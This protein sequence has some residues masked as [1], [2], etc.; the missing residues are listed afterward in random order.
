MVPVG[1]PARCALGQL[2]HSAT[3]A[4]VWAA[5]VGQLA[6]TGLAGA[7]GCTGPLDLQ[8]PLP[9]AGGLTGLLVAWPLGRSCP[10]DPYCPVGVPGPTPPWPPGRLAFTDPQ[11]LIGLLGFL[12]AYCPPWPPLTYWVALAHWPGYC[13]WPLLAPGLT[14]TWR[15]WAAGALVG[16]PSPARDRGSSAPSCTLNR[17]SS[18]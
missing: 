16:W 8:V 2:D 11:W 4:P 12:G 15:G 3:W 18:L 14:G 13:T 9:S 1:L 10:T 5:W 7:A 17:K 6:L